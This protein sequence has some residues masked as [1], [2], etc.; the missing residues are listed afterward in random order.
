M[1]LFEAIEKRRSQAHLLPQP[2]ERATIEKV[3][4]AALWAPNHHHTEPW[5]FFVFQNDARQ[6]LADAIM[7]NFHRD[8]PDASSQEIEKAQKKNPRRNMESPMVIVVSSEKGKDKN[9]TLENYAACACAVQNIL[10]AAEA[11]GLGAYWRTGDGAYTSPNAV[12][13]FLGLPESSTIVAFLLMGYPAFSEKT[14]TRKPLTEKV[15][16]FD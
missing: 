15:I 7:E 5:H 1:D 12:K 6:K 13:E 9:E 2:V 14:A 3:L 8:H 10:L 16:W 11:L 4:S